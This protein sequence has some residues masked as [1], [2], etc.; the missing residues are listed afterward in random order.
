MCLD[1]KTGLIVPTFSPER[2]GE[3]V[4]RLMN[5]PALR[6]KFGEDAHQLVTQ[7]FT[8]RHTLDE[9]ESVYNQ[10]LS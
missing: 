6:R 3:A 5:D 7:K 4:I 8:M 2:V 1:G 10:L 9:M